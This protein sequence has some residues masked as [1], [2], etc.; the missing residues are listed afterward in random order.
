MQYCLRPGCSTIIARG[1]CAK[2][3]PGREA[4]RPNVEIRKLYRSQRWRL[5]RQ[6]VLSLHPRCPGFQQWAARCGAPT[7]DVDH[8]APHR[9]DERLFWD[10]SNL[11]AYC[12]RC[13]AMKTGSGQ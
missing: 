7:S 2:H 4:A 3:D 12:H 10:V 1:Y 8:R 5:L 6:R 9:G 11:D 13:H